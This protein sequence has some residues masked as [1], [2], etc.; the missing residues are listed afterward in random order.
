MVV[1]V[2]VMVVA[3]TGGKCDAWGESVV[4]WCGCGKKASSSPVWVE[5]D[6]VEGETK[7]KDEGRRYYYYRISRERRERERERERR[8]WWWCGV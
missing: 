7:G 8:G 6:V 4:V 3:T 5:G 2:M 1:V